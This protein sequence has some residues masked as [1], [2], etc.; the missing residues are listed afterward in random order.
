MFAFET[1]LDV[2]LVSI[3]GGPVSLVG[4]I[5]GSTFLLTMRD[6]LVQDSIGLVLTAVV[7][8]LVVYFMPKGIVGF[9]RERV[10]K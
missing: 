7:L 4:P 5:V 8:I 9:V 6:F 1:T 3:I 10:L 2:I